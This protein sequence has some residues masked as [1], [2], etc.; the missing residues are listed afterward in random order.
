MVGE[1]EPMKSPRPARN[2]TQNQ[3]YIIKAILC[4]SLFK[5]HT[6]ANYDQQGPDT[7]VDEESISSRSKT[8]PSRKKIQQMR[9]SAKDPKPEETLLPLFLT[10]IQ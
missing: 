6:N 1:M 9:Q 10:H 5:T 7:K 8:H 4:T 2:T 3:L